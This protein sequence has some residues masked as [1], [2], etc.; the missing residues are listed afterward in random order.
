MNQTSK[1]HSKQT[2][3]DHALIY[4]FKGLTIFSFLAVFLSVF[5]LSANAQQ[6]NYN[7]QSLLQFLK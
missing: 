1:T 3:A 2:S 7:E 6:T 4:Q 5:T